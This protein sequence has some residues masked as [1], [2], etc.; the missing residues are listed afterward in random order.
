M[1]SMQIN[2]VSD[3]S[4]KFIR[5][6]GMSRKAFECAAAGQCFCP[7]ILGVTDHSLSSAGAESTVVASPC[8]NAMSQRPSVQCSAIQTLQL[9]ALRCDGAPRSHTLLI[10]PPFLTAPFSA[11]WRNVCLPT[12]F[13]H[14][15]APESI[16]PA[17]KLSAA[18]AAHPSFG[19]PGWQLKIQKCTSP[20]GRPPIRF[21][22]LRKVFDCSFGPQN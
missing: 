18:H 1:Q 4:F 3:S 12:C 10:I 16:L 6:G 20:L 5:V 15:A 2:T 17:R 22:C 9:C 13:S 21:T 7:P 11:L 19:D 8:L 14:Q